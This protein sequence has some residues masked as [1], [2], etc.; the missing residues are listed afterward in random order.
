LHDQ[1][2]CVAETITQKGTSGRE[3]EK[4]SRGYPWAEMADLQYVLLLT[5]FG[6]TKHTAQYLVLTVAFLAGAV[7]DRRVS[8]S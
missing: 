7:W 8:G 4:I 5:A 2:L 1:T 6:A 3:E